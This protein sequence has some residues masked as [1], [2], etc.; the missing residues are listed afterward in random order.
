MTGVYAAILGLAVVVVLLGLLCVAL[1]RSH[2]EILRHLDRLGI[3]L[4]EDQ[5]H[6][7]LSLASRPDASTGSV[8]DLSGVTPQGEPVIVSPT[9]GNDPVLIAFL[10]TTCS[11]CTVFW[12]DLDRSHLDF[13]GVRHR[14]VT[15]TLSPDEESPTRAESLASDG[16]D[17]IMSSQAWSAFQVPGAPY[18]ALV[19][20]AEGRLIGEGSA[21]DMSSL[22]SF[23]SDAAGDRRWDE[24]Q[25]GTDRTDADRERMIDEE[26]RRAGIHPG[27]PSLHPLE[28]RDED[29]SP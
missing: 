15:V 9:T 10:S 6:A 18:F 16:V 11:S 14:V 2:A 22:T 23:L 25:V 8:P 3:R 21:V 5:A 29:E 4:D 27:H 7:P 20:P 19:D 24:G 12:E 28:K 13:G 26:L 17:V 1:L